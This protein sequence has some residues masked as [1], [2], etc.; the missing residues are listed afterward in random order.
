MLIFISCASVPLE[1]D[2]TS[3]IEESLHGEST[4]LEFIGFKGTYETLGKEYDSWQSIKKVGQIPNLGKLLQDNGIAYDQSFAYFGIYSLQEIA[5]YKSKQR[6][7][8]FVEV[9]KNDFSYDYN[10][11]KQTVLT[12]IGLG[13]GTGGTIFLWSGLALKTAYSNPSSED[14]EKYYKQMSSLGD[15]YVGAGVGMDIGGL[16]LDLIALSDKPKTTIKYT[17]IYNIYV[18]D[19]VAKEIIYKDSVT[20]G[21]YVD[22]YVGDFES[23]GTDKNAVYNYYSTLACNRIIEKYDEVYKFLKSR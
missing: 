7:V 9:D 16:L 23:D 12:S 13:L 6:Y 21:P 10:H 19:T 8:T 14:N 22:A 1:L 20:A 17:G 3:K 4:E 15:G 2:K 5:E 11:V 18:Y